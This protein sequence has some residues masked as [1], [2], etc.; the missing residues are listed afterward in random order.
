MR[1]FVALEVPDGWRRAALEL[2]NRIPADLA[3]DLRFVE[4]RDLHVTLRFI[5]EVVDDRV[6][7]LQR[8]IDDL[9]PPI[10]VTL[11]PVRPGTFG[12][13]ARTS[14]AWLGI[15]GDRDGLAAIAG[16]VDRAVASA[17]GLPPEDRPYFPHVTL[18]RIT[19]QSTA[20]R[21]RAIAEA[22]ASLPALSTDAFTARECVV[23]RS[24]LGR[25]GE[26]AARYRVISRHA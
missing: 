14:A 25:L 4:A 12:A 5:G 9:V 24:H 11:R 2:Q 18:A 21:R 26:G 13:P 8:A 17:L 7:D 22:V 16:R 1:L 10:E 19:R 20:S 23:M 6:P 3:R 15:E